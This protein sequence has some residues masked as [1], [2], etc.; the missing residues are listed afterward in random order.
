VDTPAETPELARIAS[1][2]RRTDYEA[3][4][5]RPEGFDVNAILAAVREVPGVADASLRTTP[6][7]AHKLRLDLSEG[8][9]SAEVSR[10]VARLLQERMGLAAAPHDVGDADRESAIG[11]ERRVGAS[12]GAPSGPASALGTAPAA[13]PGTAPAAAPGVAAAAS[14]GVEPDEPMVPRRRRSGGRRGPSDSGEHSAT[15]A[16]GTAA[17]GVAAAGAALGSRPVA[18]RFPGGRLAE[19]PV[20][21]RPLRLGSQPGPRVRIE[22]V[23]VSTYGLEA[24]VEVR[25]TA[26]GR[27]ATGLATG[28]A[29]DSFVLRLCA[30]AAAAAVDELLR[31]AG[32]TAD[33]GRCFVE[34]A[35][36]VQ[37]G[38]CDV[39]TVIALLVYDGWV[40]QLA[41]SA[42]VTGDPREAVVRATLAAI[43]RRLEA[44][45]S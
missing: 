45:L 39:A 38:S 33:R 16:R 41:G 21:S 25:L 14:T 4:H 30:G 28:P 20:L 15:A 7:G 44:L 27:P 8:A 40:E 31:T 17:R 36:V 9:D 43:N 29:V 13:A 2:L 6:A 42:L 18:G 3:S 26:D 24:N 23:Q 34:Q 12:A 32:R 35:A 22:H 5:E 11:P 37:M 10:R 19:E 1:H